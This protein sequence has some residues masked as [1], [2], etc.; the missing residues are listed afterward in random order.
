MFLVLGR[1]N[2][3]EVRPGAAATALLHR[4]VEEAVAHVQGASL[5]ATA[6]PDF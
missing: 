1:E 2:P 4:T 6:S 3:S 5:K